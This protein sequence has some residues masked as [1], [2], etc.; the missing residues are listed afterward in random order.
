MYT[1]PDYF[2]VDELLNDEQKIVRSSIR[3]W[4]DRSVKPIIEEHAQNHTFPHHLL[5][6]MGEIGAF[7]P[8]IPEKY[9][10]AGMDY[11]S[12]GVIMTE[13]ERGDS[14]VRSAASVQTSL[15]MYPICDFGSEEQRIKT[16]FRS[17]GNY[18]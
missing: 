11:I 14:S 6:E 16:D 12:Y 2:Q 3:D 9:G 1:P 5:K 15:V 7:G 18:R 10:G 4:V 17:Y 13:L 8:F